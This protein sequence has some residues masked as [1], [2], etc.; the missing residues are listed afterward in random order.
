MDFKVEGSFSY[1]D[2]KTLKLEEG[3]TVINS[4]LLSKNEARNLAEEMFSAIM[5]LVDIDVAEK[6][7]KEHFHEVFYYESDLESYVEEQ[8]EE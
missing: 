5:D 1:G 2:Y 4:G 8:T 6:I 3:N 7:I